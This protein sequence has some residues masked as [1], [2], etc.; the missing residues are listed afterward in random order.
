[1]SIQWKPPTRRERV[2]KV[3][4]KYPAVKNCCE[5]AAIEVLRVSKPQDPSARRLKL[6][7]KAHIGPVMIVDSSRLL[8]LPKMSIGSGW[9]HHYCVET[10]EHC[11]D[12][13]TGP[14]GTERAKYLEEHFQYHD[15]IDI[16]PVD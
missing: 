13:L 4:D 2:K 8:L 16:K 12:S 1:M 14:D 3:L 10:M 11:V 9:Y 15:V 7:P 6:R 5:K